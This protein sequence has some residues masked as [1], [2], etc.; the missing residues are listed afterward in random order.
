MGTPEFA[1]TILAALIDAGHQICAVYTQPPRP[2]GRGHRLQASP[3]QQ[4]AERHGLPVH[5]PASL[6]SP[7]AQAEFAA[8]GADAAVVAAYV[9]I[10]PPAILDAPRLGCLNV[11]AS[12]LPRWRGAA[13]I[14]RA[15]LAGDKETGIT[16]MQMDAGLDTGAILLQEALPI[17]PQT[18]AGE[19]SD[20]LAVLGARLTITGLAG[21]ASGT[22]KP[23]PQ[24]QGG[25]T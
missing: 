25:A 10:L 14:Q 19:L 22:L 17:G 9:L 5:C 1:A 18:T 15:I 4:L 6:R 13:P 11:H 20:H 8:V 16:I 24:R 21:V 3:V 7:E 23:R 12:V 2:A